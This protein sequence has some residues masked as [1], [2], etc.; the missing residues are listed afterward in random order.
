LLKL[1]TNPPRPYPYILINVL[2]PKFSF[3]KYAEEVI[4]D[5]GI[6]IF[7]NP[8]IKDYPKDHISRLIKV[9]LKV[10]S[11]VHPKP[12][13][14]TCPDY[15]DDYHPKALWIS[16][17]YTNIE[18]TIENVLK[19]TER[20]DWIP[21]LPVIQGWNK[22]PD[23]VLRCIKLYRQHGLLDKFNYFAVGNLCVEPDV[24]VICKT[25]R[26]VRK[27]LPNH[28]LHVFG[29]K[30]NAIKKTFGLIDSCDTMAWTRPVDSKLNANYSCK[31]QQERVS[32]FNRWLEKF[33]KVVAQKTLLDD[34]LVR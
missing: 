12:I 7:R 30:L 31:S 18:R 32:F 22:N 2:K 21:W 24:T 19:Y 29:L 14:V 3:L 15:C 9:Y 8:N 1:F 11:I 20:F 34:K 4:I 33:N 17:D 28:K 27:A 6:E 23:S 5:S 16:E 26:L 10:R 13:H 25:I